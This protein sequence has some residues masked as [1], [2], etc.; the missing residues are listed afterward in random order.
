MS[1]PTGDHIFISYSHNDTDFCRLVIEQLQLNDFDDNEIWQDTKSIPP[2]QQWF[3]QLHFALESAYAVIV[4]VSDSSLKSHWVTYEYAWA[5]GNNIPIIALKNS[6]VKGIET[7]PIG[8]IHIKDFD[9]GRIPTM[10]LDELKQFRS[11]SA[12]LRYLELSIALEMMPLKILVYALNWVTRNSKVDFWRMR[13]AVSQKAFEMYTINLPRFWLQH[14]QAFQPGHQRW[15]EELLSETFT[16]WQSTPSTHAEYEAL[17]YFHE[18]L[19]RYVLF[20][21]KVFK[22]AEDFYGSGFGGWQQYKDYLSII[23]G[24]EVID[25]FFSGDGS[26]R[27]SVDGFIDRYLPKGQSNNDYLVKV[28]WQDI[29]AV[30]K[31]LSTN[32]T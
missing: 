4:L 11:T 10:V 14:S 5:R 13:Q 27:S 16:L 2:S 31:E 20:L 21:D 17:I 29:E 18:T 26:H 23:S 3:Q 30:E 1:S 6:S 8:A 22:P 32:N 25:T 15:F 24:E 7:H 9:D 12:L 19:N 28:L